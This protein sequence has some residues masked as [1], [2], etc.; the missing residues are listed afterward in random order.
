MLSMSIWV[1][2]VDGCLIDSLTGTSLRPGA[3]ALLDHLR[4]SGQQVVWWSAGGQDYA[5]RR[6]VAVGILELVDAFHGKDQRG[7]AGRY[8]TDHFLTEDLTAAVFVNDRPE[9]LPIG[10]S[11][12]AVSPYLGANPH[13]RGLLPAGVRAGLSAEELYR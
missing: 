9:D 8:L 6:A 1:F 11:V 3:R 13:D 2:D 7:D 4:R 10:A 12:V 5:R